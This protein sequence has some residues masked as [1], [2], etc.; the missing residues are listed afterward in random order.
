MGER[1]D[2]T[3]SDGVRLSAVLLHA[4]GGPPGLGVV[5]A[6]G[7]TGS[8]DRP[9]VWRVASALAAHATV[10]LSDHR[11]HGL[12]AGLSTLGDREVLDVDAGVAELRRRGHA[13]IVTC[14]WSMGGSAVLRQAALR[15]RLLHGHR[16]AFP[17]DAVVSVSATSRWF[18]RDT[19]PMRRLHRLVETRSGRMLA[20]RWLGVR[21]DGRAWPEIPESPIDCVARIA[22]IPLLVV[23]GDR[24]AFFTVE[25]PQALTAAAAG[26]HLWIVPGFGHAEAAADAAL[27]DRIGRFLPTLLADVGAP[28]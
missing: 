13:P 18:V 2:L 26:A 24:D 20:R 27:L 19:V 28:A 15:G 21:I 12:S 4:R 3:T 1:L 10:L 25:H 22:P 6:H 16:V 7:F 8:A 5:L 17:P 23:H 9:H 11:G 14:G